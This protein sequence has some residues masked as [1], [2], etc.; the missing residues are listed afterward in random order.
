MYCVCNR[1]RFIYTAV[2]ACLWFDC[3]CAIKS[4]F[5]AIRTSRVEVKVHFIL[6]SQFWAIQLVHWKLYALGHP[7]PVAVLRT[8]MK[9]TPCRLTHTQLGPT[10]KATVHKWRVTVAK[11]LRI[12]NYTENYEGEST[13][14]TD[15]SHSHCKVHTDVTRICEKQVFHGVFACSCTLHAQCVSAEGVTETN[16]PW[17]VSDLDRKLLCVS[18]S[19]CLWAVA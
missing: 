12:H 3:V 6:R 4:Q 8:A 10:G 15:R 18:Y 16:H 11:M 13:S 17:R 1:K 19:S 5:V 9:E 2:R 7:V 14:S